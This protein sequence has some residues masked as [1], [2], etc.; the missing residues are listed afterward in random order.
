[1]TTIASINNKLQNLLSQYTSL[2][3][4]VYTRS[5]AA[6]TQ[7]K[8]LTRSK[9]DLKVGDIVQGIQ[10]IGFIDENENQ[11]KV[12][13]GRV[14]TAVP[15]FG[16]LLKTNYGSPLLSSSGDLLYDITVPMT[17][18]DVFNLFNIT[19]R[20][21][22][23]AVLTSEQITLAAISVSEGMADFNA[24][25]GYSTVPLINQ[26]GD[27]LL[28]A[29]NSLLARL[30]GKKKYI[31]DDVTET[32]DLANSLSLSSLT[33][34]AP[35]NPIPIINYSDP[36][37]RLSLRT[38]EDIEAY[39]LTSVRDVNQVI[40][41]HTNTYADQFVSYDSLYYR[42]VTVSRLDDVSC[43]F[44]ITK[45]GQVITARNINTVAPFADAKHNDFSIAV[46]LEGG[47]LGTA[48]SG[49]VKYSKKS[50]T[51]AQFIAFKTFLKAFYT[52]YPGGQVWGKNDLDQN[53][54]EP[55][56]NVTKYIDRVF[57]K[58]NTQ[59]IA[60][61]RDAGSLSTDDLIFSQKR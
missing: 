52:I 30:P 17:T 8:Q 15:V 61:V 27:A 45:E 59:S 28:D 42:D 32:K 44:I 29:S 20:S 2:V 47:L 1:M 3:G 24:T 34:T 16:S 4:G 56:F 18:Q 22:L 58:Q 43:H 57:D 12:A 36:T 26:A 38:L 46:M 49:N 23:S 40:V 9:K 21:Y 7:L 5:L 31:L 48:G 6:T 13:L 10:V 55:E 19:L 11:E 33:E 51:K 39:L 41:G 53:T 60:Q 37:P 25:P 50:F 35:R 14:T 54:S